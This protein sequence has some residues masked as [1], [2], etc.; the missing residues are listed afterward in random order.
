L[1]YR[2]YDL[3]FSRN[4]LCHIEVGLGDI[5]PSSV[6]REEEANLLH[7]VICLEFAFEPINFILDPQ[8]SPSKSHQKLASISQNNG[9]LLRT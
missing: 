5:F 4:P 2:L 9:Q 1:F 8:P 7:S 3:A 6:K